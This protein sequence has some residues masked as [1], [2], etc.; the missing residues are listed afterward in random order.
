MN[1]QPS[2]KDQRRLARL[3]RKTHE[4]E[5]K[6]RQRTRRVQIL[7][8][9]V[10]VA[11]LAISYAVWASTRPKALTGSVGSAGSTGRAKAPIVTVP[12]QGRDHV[13][14]GQPH[15]P[16]NSNPPASGWHYGTTSPW[17]FHNEE[18]PDEL[19]IH[20]LEHGGIWITYKSADDTEVVDRLLALSRRFPRKI[21]ITLRTKNDSRIAVVAWDHV[22]KLD[23]YDEQQIIDFINRFKNKGP[24]FVP[25]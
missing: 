1:K 25:D 9:V 8:A 4:A 18:L 15:P 14:P 21:I 24:E 13:P 6:K 3:E 22:V 19:V 5:R 20:N 11:A 16:Y 10:V 12:D 7:A 2:K 23:H 17:G